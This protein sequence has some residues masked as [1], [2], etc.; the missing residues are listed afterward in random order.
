MPT[1]ALEPANPE[2][3]AIHIQG[4]PFLS[5]GG[6]VGK[7]MKEY[8]SAPTAPPTSTW[9]RCR[10]IDVEPSG[11]GSASG[12]G[13]AP[14]ARPDSA[15][16]SA[17]RTPTTT[18][19]TSCTARIRAMPRFCERVRECACLNHMP[20]SRYPRKV[21]YSDG[22]WLGHRTNPAILPGACLPDN[23]SGPPRPRASYCGAPMVISGGQ[24]AARA[25]RRATHASRPAATSVIRRI[26]TILRRVRSRPGSTASSGASRARRTR[27]ATASA[28][29]SASIRRWAR[30]RRRRPSSAA[31]TGRAS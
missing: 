13:A 18:S 17:T 1:V 6:G 12:R 2:Q 24:L 5:W 16:W 27:T 21:D 29:R 28:A 23:H 7:A 19:R 10:P 31:T 3:R 14:T 9:R 30:S 11:K 8:P 26:P 15:C 25:A 4:G 20:C 22:R